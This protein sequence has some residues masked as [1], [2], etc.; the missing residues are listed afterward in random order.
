MTKVIFRITE[1]DV[2]AVFPEIPWNDNL[3]TS[4]Q[5]NEQHAGCSTDWI[6]SRTRPAT[7]VE[8]APLL[9]ELKTIGYDDI[10]VLSRMPSK[11]MCQNKNKI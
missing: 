2:I 6:R 3:L 9:Q 11:K 8:Y 4:Y 7:R 1:D 10:K 5:H